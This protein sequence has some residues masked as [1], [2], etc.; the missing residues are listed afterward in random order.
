MEEVRVLVVEDDAGVGRLMSRLL[1]RLEVPHRVVTSGPAAIEVLQ[2]QGA[3]LVLV[4]GQLGLE[5]AE[6]FVPAFRAAAP[7]AKIVS[8]SGAHVK[9]DQPRPPY[10]GVAAKPMLREEMTALLD[11]W[12]PR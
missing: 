6:S 2:A 3:A 11:R 1:Q 7:A 10:D 9:T 4:D 5:R 12:I 8:I